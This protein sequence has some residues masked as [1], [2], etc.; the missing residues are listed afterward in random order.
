[1]SSDKKTNQAVVFHDAKMETTYSNVANVASGQDEFA[2][3]FGLGRSWHGK[4]ENF[5]VDLQHRIIM[6]PKTAKRLAAM[7]INA[8]SQH[9]QRFGKIDALDEEEAPK[10]TAAGEDNKLSS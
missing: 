5:D 10:Q 8:L 2:V 9:E 6:T 7:M 4:G 1:M 3:L